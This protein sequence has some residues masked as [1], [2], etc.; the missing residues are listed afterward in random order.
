MNTINCGTYIQV[1]K[2]TPYNT[3][4][5]VVLCIILIIVDTFE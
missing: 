2:L 5:A 1:L 4:E 3:S